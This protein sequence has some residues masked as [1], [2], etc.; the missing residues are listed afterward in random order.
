MSFTPMLAEPVQVL[1]RGP[2]WR[3]EPKY[4]GMRVLGVAS[5]HSA[6][7]LSREGYDYSKQIPEVV[8]ALAGLRAAVG[9]DI[10]LDGELVACLSDGYAGYHALSHRLGVQ[11]KFRIRI[12]RNRTPAALVSFDLLVMGARPLIND[13]LTVRRAALVELLS[14]HVDPQLRISDHSEDGDWMRARAHAEGWE[15]V[16]AKQAHSR[17]LPGKRSSAWVKYK[18]TLRQEFVIAGFTESDRRDHLRAVLAGYYSGGTLVYAGD[19]G[20]GFTAKSLSAVR[21]VLDPLVQT[22]CPFTVAPKLERPNRR[23]VWVTPRVLAEVQFDCWTTDGKMRFARFRG[24]R[25]DKSPLA[26][27]RE[28]H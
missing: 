23:P 18:P 6:Q 25:F 5:S 1:P 4:D 12:L 8:E 20:S 13:P 27:V 7:I 9:A 19:V 3:Y 21:S 26:V 28:S 17:Y 24:L 2:E 14:A 11:D 15:G 10:I 16:M 22:A